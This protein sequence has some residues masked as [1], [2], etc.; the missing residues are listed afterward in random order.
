MWLKISCVD[1]ANECPV[2]FDPN[3]EANLI[4]K[5]DNFLVIYHNNSH[6]GTFVPWDLRQWVRKP[7][8][9][10]TPVP[11]PL[12]R[13]QQMDL[14]RTRADLERMISGQF[15]ESLHL[16]YKSSMA[17]SKP[18]NR[19]ELAK[20]VSS[21]ANSDGGMIVYG[22]EEEEH[23][24]IRIDDGIDHDIYNRE[25]FENVILGNIAPRLDGIVIVQIPLSSDRSA[26][27]IEIPKS[28]RGPH[29][30]R[31]YHR[32]YKR[33]NFQA[34]PMEDYEIADVRFDLQIVK[35]LINF[36]IDD[37]A[38]RPDPISPL[39]TSAP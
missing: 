34:E 36:D 14:P 28:Y 5:P 15:Q 25:W 27:A 16:E 7:Q 10:Y 2:A 37:R 6:C 22:I 33:Y 38:H 31:G 9:C 26:Y 29:Q 35:S 8:S 24:P 23:L 1:M 21:F 18:S 11:N 17:V 4:C 19:T 13:S 3:L 32:Y 12:A 30:E 20:D 39:Q